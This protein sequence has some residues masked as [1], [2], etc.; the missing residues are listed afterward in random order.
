[1]IVLLALLALLAA[2]AEALKANV[3]DFASFQAAVGN[4]AVTD[5]YVTSGFVFP[6]TVTIAAGRSVN[7]WGQRGAA[8]CVFDG[9]G[10][11]RLF[12]IA[13]GASAN[14]T[15]VTFNKGYAV[16]HSN[17]LFVYLYGLCIRPLKPAPPPLSLIAACASLSFL[18][19]HVCHAR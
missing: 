3:A 8:N 16:R 5:V 10:K 15:S 19:Y 14:F 9:A 1:M 12:S 4:V 7:V 17:V 18:S 6:S 11:V 2:H 13:T